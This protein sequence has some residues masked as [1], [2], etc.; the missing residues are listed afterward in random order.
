MKLKKKIERKKKC[1]EVNCCGVNIKA[2]SDV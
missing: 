1:P 2:N